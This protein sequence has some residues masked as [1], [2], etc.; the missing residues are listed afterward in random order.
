MLHLYTQRKYKSITVY[1]NN[2]IGGGDSIILSKGTLHFK[3]A[4]KESKNKLRQRKSNEMTEESFFNYTIIIKY[5][6]CFLIFLFSDKLITHLK[7]IFVLFFSSNFLLV[8]CYNNSKKGA[9]VFITYSVLI[10]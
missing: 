4:S 6:F 3:C 5:A 10:M 7:N 9:W 8:S 2:K 1:A